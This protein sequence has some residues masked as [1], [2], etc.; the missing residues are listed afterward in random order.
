[1]ER[2]AFLMNMKKNE[3]FF[4][5]ILFLAYFVGIKIDFID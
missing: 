4:I 1:M 5:I 2:T 3:I